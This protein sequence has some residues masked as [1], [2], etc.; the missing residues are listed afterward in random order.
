MLWRPYGAAGRRDSMKGTLV[1][2]KQNT[3]AFLTYA[4]AFTFA[5]AYAYTYAYA[6]AYAYAY[7][8]VQKPFV[9]A[10]CTYR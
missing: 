2:N 9:N 1:Q 10:L 6:Y 3:Y 5:Y 7:G 8:R 4:Y